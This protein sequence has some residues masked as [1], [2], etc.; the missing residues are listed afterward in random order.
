MWDYGGIVRT[1]DRLL[2]AKEELQLIWKG[3]EKKYAESALSEPLI[4]LR[5][6]AETAWIITNSASSHTNLLKDSLGGHVLA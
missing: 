3:V 5:H 1:K 4:E 2:R 6:M